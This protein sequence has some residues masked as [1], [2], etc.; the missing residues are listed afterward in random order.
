MITMN[1]RDRVFSALRRQVPDRVPML[2]FSIDQRVI[3]AICPECDYF[4]FV[5]KYGLDAVRV[6]QQY[7]DFKDSCRV[8]DAEKNIIVDKWG[9]TR[10]YSG[11]I[12]W[13]AI[14]A[15][16][17]S[18]KDLASYVPPDPEAD[19]VLGRLPQIVNRFKGKKAIIYALNDSFLIPSELRGLENLFMD[20][21]ENPAFAH[22]IIDMCVEYSI[23][24][25]RRAIKAGAEII[26][27]RDD[28]AYKNGLMMSPAH[29]DEFILPGLSRIVRAIKEAGA[30]A[31]KHCDGN[32]WSILDKIVDTGVDAINPLEPVAGMEI[33]EVKKKYGEKVCI[34]GNIDCGDL[35]CHGNPEEVEA[36]VIRCIRAAAPGGG[37]ILSSSN[38]ISSAADP[39]NFL[40]M[41]EAGRK[42]GSYPLSLPSL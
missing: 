35:L 2:E 17:K 14:D 30:F 38:S 34:I 11:E 6:G 24:E 42:Y 27:L 23:I 16:I 32:I 10:Q 12:L 5:E 1:S 37:Y 39:R 28:Y 19:G 29:F 4:D 31:V 8:I 26:M 36:E 33:E 25:V 21:I 18:E 9:I 20:Y 15:P 22:K 7:P 3:S 13:F 40:A 41:I